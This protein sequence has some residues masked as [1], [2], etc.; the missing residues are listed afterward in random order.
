MFDVVGLVKTVASPLTSYF[1]N[2][3]KIKA[4]SVESKL[5]INEAKTEAQCNKLLNGQAGDIAW[6][7]T[8]IENAGWKDEYLLIV[9]SLP[10]ILCFIPSMTQVVYDGFTAL[11]NCPT[12]Y[13]WA[14]SIAVGSSFGVKEITKFKNIMK[15]E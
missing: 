2:K 5:K 1:V 13:R 12:W 11:G 15:G 7:N 3:Q 4:A 9:L 8:S 6:E 14:F 10:A